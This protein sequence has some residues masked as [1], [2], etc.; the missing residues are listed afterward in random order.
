MS[1]HYSTL[2]PLSLLPK[3]VQPLAKAY[4]AAATVLAQH[5]AEHG[6]VNSENAIAQAAAADSALVR[7]ALLAGKSGDDLLALG[8]PNE[9]HRAALA[10]AHARAVAAAIP[11]AS[12]AQIALAAALVENR[13][14]VIANARK[15]LA[16]HA[17]AYTDA[18]AS[19]LEARRSYNLALEGLTWAFNIEG[20]DIPNYGQDATPPV[21]SDVLRINEEA[22]RSALTA[23]AQRH[24]QLERAEERRVQFA[25]EN[26]RA[27]AINRAEAEAVNAKRAEMASRGV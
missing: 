3:S 15:A 13:D 1:F 25:A 17:D 8:S 6:V 26:A 2:A 27:D 10:A 23:D 20:R 22:L 24:D 12:D 14:A 18:V 4:D 11:A 5:Q 7:D 21:E 16:S 19:M 9:S